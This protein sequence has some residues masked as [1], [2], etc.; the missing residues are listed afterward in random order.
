[1]DSEIKVDIVDLN[2][3]GGKLKLKPRSK[4]HGKKM[5]HK[6]KSSKSHNKNH[7]SEEKISILGS[8]MSFFMPSKKQVKSHKKDKGDRH[9]KGDKHN[10]GDRHN[11]DEHSEESV[12]Y[13]NEGYET[14]SD[15]EEDEESES[16]ESEEEE[17]ESEP[18]KGFHKITES[19]SN[20]IDMA[21]KKIN[22]KISLLEDDIKIELNK[23]TSKTNNITT[24]LDTNGNETKKVKESVN[25]IITK[26]N[27][28][29]DSVKDKPMSGGGED[30]I[31]NMLKIRDS[32]DYI[33]GRL[34]KL[35]EDLTFQSSIYKDL[36]KFFKVVTELDGDNIEIM[37][38]YLIGY[39]DKKFSKGSGSNEN[40]LIEVLAR[41]KNKTSV[42]ATNFANAYKLGQ[43]DY[44]N[45]QS[46]L[47]KKSMLRVMSCV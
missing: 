11:K 7:N 8:L 10:K 35:N 14:E 23:L 43:E 17:E 16:E 28:L 4:S 40:M 5:R 34:V 25:E 12:D 39:D 38:G 42:T 22:S 13:S 6:K 29:K 45:N 24:L 18:V 44:V 30:N 47:Y 20:E 37:S 33:L 46:I 2:L 32:L 1:M 21:T 26:L 19:L 36:D 27:D 31:D 3:M 15:E 9:N 41:H